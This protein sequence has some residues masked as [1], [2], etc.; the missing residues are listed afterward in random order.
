[1]NQLKLAT[2]VFS[3]HHSDGKAHPTHY[4]LED[5]GNVVR[6]Q[7]KND[8]KVVEWKK[9]DDQLLLGHSEYEFSEKTMLAPSI[10]GFCYYMA[11][12]PEME[13]YKDG[14]LYKVPTNILKAHMKTY[15]SPWEV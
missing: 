14:G 5:E 15:K 2:R 10:D 12:L 7:S 4:W 9:K 13:Q 3:I 8:S 1:M 11:E 6:L